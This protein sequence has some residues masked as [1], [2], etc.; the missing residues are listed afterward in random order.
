[1]RF[2]IPP[3]PAQLP[4]DKLSIIQVFALIPKRCPNI[5]VLGLGMCPISNETF[6]KIVDVSIPF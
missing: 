2:E 4:I 5:R 6:E 1:M 3:P